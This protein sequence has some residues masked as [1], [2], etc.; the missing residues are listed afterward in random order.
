M[1][2]IKITFQLSLCLWIQADAKMNMEKKI[3]VKTQ[4]YRNL[5]NKAIFPC[6]N[7]F[8]PFISE[9]YDAFRHSAV[10]VSSSTASVPVS[11]RR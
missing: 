10:T 5:L 6:Q 8:R 9:S 2:N 4:L 11:Q 1:A 7:V 3:N